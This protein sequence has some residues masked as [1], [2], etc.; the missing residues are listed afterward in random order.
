[1]WTRLRNAFRSKPVVVESR[2]SSCGERLDEHVQVDIG[3]AVLDT[4]EDTE[5]RRLIESREWAAAITHQAANATADIR[6]WRVLRCGDGR[7]AVVARVMPIEVWS[8]D[9]YEEPQFLSTDEASELLRIV[10]LPQPTK[11]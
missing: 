8:D 11:V 2:C 3:S 9:Y 5:L 1:M 6:A 10:E 4:A 7:I